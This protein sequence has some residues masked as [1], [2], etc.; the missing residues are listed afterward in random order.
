MTHSDIPLTVAIPA[1]NRGSQIASLLRTIEEQASSRDDLL[2]C[3][4]GSTDA[5]ADIAS[6]FTRWRV[7]RRER[8]AG[9][10]VNW[11][12]CLE[13]AKHEWICI[14]HDD[15][16]PAEKCLS[17]LRTACTIAGRAAVIAHK[18]EGTA[19]DAAFRY[20]YWE[21]GPWSALHAPQVPSGVTIHRDV[22]N[23]VGLFD[24]RFRY[25]ADLE[26]FARAAARFPTLTI[27]SPQVVEYRLHGENYQFETWDKADFYPEFEELQRTVLAHAGFKGTREAEEMLE[28]RMVGTLMYIMRLADAWNKRSTVRRAARLLLNR[29]R[30]VRRR[31]LLVGAFAALT[32]KRLSL[33][34]DASAPAGG[35]V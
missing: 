23:A 4:D 9:M 13:Q 33:R 16:L 24:T 8:N 6:T 17:L 10:V 21:P 26:Y 30:F 3:D 20:R 2:V 29:R 27:E 31:D 32:G 35:S 18:A 5:T 12:S 19:V 14:I 1:Y 7:I 15:D 25:S 11:N 28:R 34:R 22:I